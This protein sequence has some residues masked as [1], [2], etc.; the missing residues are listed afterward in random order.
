MDI[1]ENVNLL[2]F[3][4]VFNRSSRTVLLFLLFIIP[5]HMPPTEYSGCA[6]AAKTAVKTTVTIKR[7][8]PIVCS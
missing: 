6:S 3:P 4:P 5:V 2:S 8:Y 1:F 7:R